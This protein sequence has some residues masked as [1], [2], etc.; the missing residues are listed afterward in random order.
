MGKRKRSK[1]LLNFLFSVSKF[2]V[3]LFL[4]QNCDHLKTAKDSILQKNLNKMVTGKAYSLF[5][6]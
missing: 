6:E 4:H 2:N 1:N 3:P 5:Q